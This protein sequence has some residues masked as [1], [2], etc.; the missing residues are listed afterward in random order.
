MKLIYETKKNSFMSRILTLVCMA[1]MVFVFLKMDLTSL[2]F[3]KVGTPAPQINLMSKEQVSEISAIMKQQNEQKV[4]NP[5]ESIEQIPKPMQ[6]VLE[7]RNQIYESGSV[8][9]YADESG[10]IVMVDDLSKVPVK[11]REKMKVSAGVSGQQRTAVKVMNNQIWVPVTLGHKG[12]TVTAL[13]LLDTGATNTS[14]SPELAR[15]L[16]VLAGETTR[17]RATLADGRMV[18]TAHVVFDHVMVGPKVKYNLDV[19][20]LPRSGNEVTGLLGM[21]FLQNFPYIIESREGVIRWQ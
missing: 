15:R 1:A 18:Q 21:N 13:L 5:V 7:P 4:N 14:I 6:P 8:Y 16:G 19:Q 10:M 12:A 3:G 11:F 17:G 2:V 20:I 9:Q